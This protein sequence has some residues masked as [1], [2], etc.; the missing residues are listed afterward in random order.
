MFF[1]P[2]NAPRM[3]GYLASRHAGAL[4]CESVTLTKM[5]MQPTLYIK[6]QA[7]KDEFL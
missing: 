2:E 4:D 3:K 6:G 7:Q 5:S 1:S